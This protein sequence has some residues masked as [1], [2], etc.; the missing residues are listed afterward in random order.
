LS[1]ACGK[2]WKLIWRT[3][4]YRDWCRS[5]FFHRVDASIRAARTTPSSSTFDTKILD[6]TAVLQC[7]RTAWIST[8]ED[9]A[10][11]VYHRADTSWKVL[12]EW[13]MCIITK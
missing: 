10:N 11:D 9:Y 6:Y 3:R 2:G 12:T 7:L 1:S 4:C 5:S 13:M 8:F